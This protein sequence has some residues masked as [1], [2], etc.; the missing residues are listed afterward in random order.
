[1]FQQHSTAI[2]K[3]KKHTKLVVIQFQKYGGRFVKQLAQQTALQMV[4]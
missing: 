4:K 1:M 3:K 2:G